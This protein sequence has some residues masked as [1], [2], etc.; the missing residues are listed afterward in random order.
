V[1]L[2]RFIL[3]LLLLLP[4]VR[5][6]AYEEEIAQWRREREASLKKEG[7]WL[8]VAG[9]FWLKPGVNTVGTD[10]ASALALPKGPTPSIVGRFIFENGEV[11][12]EPQRGVAATLN[13]SPASRQ[14]MKPDTSGA[15]DVLRINTLTMFVIQRGNRTGVRLKDSNNPARRNFEGL[16]YFPLKLDYRVRAQY[17]PYDPPK[18]IKITNVLGETSED[19]CPGI[20]EFDLAGK[21]FRLE[22]LLEGDELFFIFK[23]K[24]AGRETY[25]AGRF[26]YA[27]T[28]KASEV[29]LDFNKAINPP[30]AF[31][32]FATCPLPPPQNRL[33]IRVEAGELHYGH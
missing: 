9:L 22:P 26:L 24:T 28:P 11:T 18:K 10:P 14:M 30:C 20:V 2:L 17:T 6:P 23:D 7:G 1:S 4:Q 8:E 12:F 27:N 13:G 21:H 19:V 15:P 16:E 29:I 3:P 25:P 31:T 32:P 33:A 5:Q